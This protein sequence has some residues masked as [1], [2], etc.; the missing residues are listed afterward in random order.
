MQ[1]PSQAKV[2]VQAPVLIEEK[3]LVTGITKATEVVRV[4]DKASNGH[5]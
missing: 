3:T 2:V 5:E 4:M 1:A